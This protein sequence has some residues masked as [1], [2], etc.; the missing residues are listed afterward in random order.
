M[1]RKYSFFV[2]AFKEW[3]LHHYDLYSVSSILGKFCDRIL[4]EYHGGP[5]LNIYDAK[6]TQI[7]SEYVCLVS[8]IP[9]RTKWMEHLWGHW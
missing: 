9:H 6:D 2:K 1:S 8:Q 4:A 3:E 7:H 5:P